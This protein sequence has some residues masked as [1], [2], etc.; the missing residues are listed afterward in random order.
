MKCVICKNGDVGQ[1]PVETEIKI[2]YEHLMVT[3]QAEACA[4]C[5]EG[6]YSPEALRYIEQ[7][8][9]EFTQKKIVQP[10]V[11]KVYQIS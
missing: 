9:E 6:Y 5:G 10:S 8:R 2:G 3:V 7:L 1:A 11:G 4:E